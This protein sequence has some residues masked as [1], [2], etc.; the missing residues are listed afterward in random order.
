[1]KEN[2]KLQEDFSFKEIIKA[3]LDQKKIILAVT[4][5]ITVMA[6]VVSFFILT[7]K[8]ESSMSFVMRI[9]ES[10]QTKAGTYY[11]ITT[12]YNDYLPLLKDN[13][14]LDMTA[15]SL[16]LDY[17]GSSLR[18]R[19]SFEPPS[20]RD[21]SQKTI[22][23]TVAGP[24]GEENALI[25]NE[26]INNYIE[27]LNIDFK[28]K[29]IN[30]FIRDYSV[31]LDLLEKNIELTEKKLVESE[32]LISEISPFITLQKALSSNPEV[33]AKYASDK[34]VN[35]KDLT[36]DMLY[37]EI[38]NP[39][40]SSMD[41]LILEYKKYIS[42]S[43]IEKE[44]YIELLSELSHE[45]KALDH[46]YETKDKSMFKDQYIE[47]FNTNIQVM[48]PAIASSKPVSPKIGLNI[49]ISI[50]LGFMLG[51]SIAFFKIYWDNN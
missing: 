10:I 30:Q 50:V 20:S 32:R 28:E 42:D 23:L 44:R 11:Y 13:R 45:K 6:L 18:N 15:E 9:P 36:D 43:N 8:Y 21:E 25:A 38:L 31:K 5:V 29:A 1:M 3:L 17:K 35:V 4:S 7:P 49:A 48:S 2:M 41:S 34:G 19:I 27:Y 37:D 51:I 39:N 24:D 22:K 47:V 26:L 16:G 40:Y 33:A 46:Y 14:V 12:S